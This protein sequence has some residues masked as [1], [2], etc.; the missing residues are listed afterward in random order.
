VALVSRGVFAL[1]LVHVLLDR[2]LG[3]V[4]T[5]LDGLLGAIVSAR[6]AGMEVVVM[7]AIAMRDIRWLP[8]GMLAYRMLF[9]HGY[10]ASPVVVEVS[11]DGLDAGTALPLPISGSR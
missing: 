6:S 10:S 2:A 5:D 11:A 3:C 4:M 9:F 7:L 1:R 8:V